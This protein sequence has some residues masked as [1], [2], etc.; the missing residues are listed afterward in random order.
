MIITN[1]LKKIEHTNNNDLFQFGYYLLILNQVFSQSQFNEVS[2]GI[3]FLKVTRWMLMVYFF[4]LIVYKNIYPKGNK[5]LFWFLLFAAILYEMIFYNG[6]LLLLIML[7]VIV[8]SYRIDVNNMIKNHVLALWS[9]IVVIVICSI[10]GIL[11]V[12][13]NA[14]AFDNVTG[15]LFRPNN[16]RYNLGFTH[17]N[18]IPIASLFTYLYIVIIK[19][20]KFKIVWDL[21]AIIINFGIYLLCG[22]RSC[23]ILLI[24]AVVLRNCFKKLQ[25]QCIK[26][27]VPFSLIL[28]MVILGFS[29]FLPASNYFNH[30]LV[31]RLNILLSAR[32]T[33]I[34]KI[35]QLYP[36]NF[37]GYGEI[38]FNNTS[39]EYLALDNGYITLL[40]TRGIF[41]SIL[42]LLMIVS[43]MLYSKRSK[44]I[45]ISLFMIIMI[46]GNTIDNSL[47]HYVTFPIYIMLFN[48]FRL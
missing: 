2:F 42:F 27:V 21:E 41:I 18:I 16:I 19:K 14:K 29:I 39:T 38:T 11:E 13:G 1:I 40:V 17:F 10:V 45:Y 9:G 48:E 22:S 3:Y 8:G 34:R 46:L 32:L 7:L 36:L 28:L 44:K 6:K 20:D 26:L 15:F 12:Q 37:W 43:M 24:L 35:L 23:I 25:K 5:G 47:L 30:P 31:Q 4:V 33:L